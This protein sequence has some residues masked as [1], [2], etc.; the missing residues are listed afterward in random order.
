MRVIRWFLVLL[1]LVAFSS[2]LVWAQQQTAG[3]GGEHQMADLFKV[4]FSW[5]AVSLTINSARELIS[6]VASGSNALSM[7]N[8]ARVK[9]GVGTD[10]T[11]EGNGSY[12]KVGSTAAGYV[13][14]GTPFTLSSVYVNN[15]ILAFTYGGATLPAR[16]F[17][18]TDIAYNVRLGG[19]GGTDGGATDNV[20]FQVS[21]GT[22]T[23][24]CAFRCD[25]DAGSDTTP[26]VND[27]GA[28]CVFAGSNALTYGFSSVGSCTVKTDILGNIDVR[29]RWQ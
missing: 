29:G 11:I 4:F 19:A 13:A 12:L 28:G 18:V 2:R 25:H 27:A 8:G 26:C 1:T 17:T 23:C 15:T 22:N 6:T 14:S 24:G 16:A 3:F 5:D 10:T 7:G 21:D 9:Y 20:T